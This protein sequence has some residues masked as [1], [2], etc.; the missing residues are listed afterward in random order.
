MAYH[1]HFDPV[2]LPPEA[3]EL[4]QEPPRHQGLC[5][6]HR[7]REPPCG[8]QY[9]KPVQHFGARPAEIVRDPG[10][11]QAGLFERVPQLFRPTP[12]LGRVDGLRLA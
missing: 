4:R 2:D 11:G 5:E 1:F 12:F 7:R 3:K 8:A 10:Q 9:R 6:R